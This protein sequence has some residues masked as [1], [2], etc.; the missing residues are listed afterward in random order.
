MT[1][2]NFQNF[3][4]TVRGGTAPYSLTTHYRQQTAEGTFAADIFQ[5][6]WRTHVAKME[7]TI[8]IPDEALLI[9]AGSELFEH[10]M[11]DGV[12]DLW[13]EA[14]ADLDQH[15]IY[16]LRLRLALH[17]PAVA[18]LPWE[19]LYDPDRNQA[20]AANGR[21]PVVRVENL[22]RFVG[23]PRS[24]QISWPLRVLLAA[25]EDPSGEIDANTEITGVT[26]V[27]DRFGP[28]QVQVSMLTGR[29]SIIDLRREIDVRQPDLLHV[30]THGDPHGIA[31]WRRD[32]PSMVSSASLRATL[33]RT[34]SVKLAFLNACLAGLSSD[35][36]RF[37]NVATQLLQAGLPA[38]IAMQNEIRDD[39]AIEFAQFLYEELVSGSCPGAIDAAVALARTSLY[40][41]NPGDFSYGTP[42]L[43]LN[44]DSGFVFSPDGEEDA[45][46]EPSIAPPP[47]EFAPRISAPIDL[48]TEQQWLREFESSVELDGLPR[49]VRFVARDWERSVF[50]IH[51]LLHQLRHLFEL[52]DVAG[53]DRKAAEYQTQ[54]SILVRLQHH[55]DELSSSD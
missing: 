42:V 53:Y 34:P 46:P 25:P 8:F 33:E 38:V 39:S 40:A 24:L 35:T 41:L 13:I 52:G 18:A 43:W 31:L 5:E 6:T 32:Q 26:Q 50:E 16:G 12:R 23:P 10:V 22:H 20:F 11:Q 36:H 1:A 55:I 21:T 54:K 2:C 28:D 15:R 30:I 3:D 51:S 48:D 9:R 44:A 27:L 7:D 49:D 37:H 19:A 29:F 45:A 17:P 4:I 14:R 47:G